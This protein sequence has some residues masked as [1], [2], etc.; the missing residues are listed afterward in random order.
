MLARMASDRPSR[1]VRLVREPLV[2]FALGGAL[3]FALYGLVGPR[4]PRG[5]IVVGAD[6]QTALARRFERDHGRA[7][8]AEELEGLVQSFVDEELLV[9]EALALGLD[10]GDPIVR[11]RL[12]Q[13]LR[14]LHEDLAVIEEPD[15]VA[16]QAHLEAHPERY[17]RGVRVDLEHVFVA[18]RG[19]VGRA[20]AEGL[21]E[22]LEGGAAPRGLGDPFAHGARILDADSDR[23]DRLFG[24][25][26]AADVLD[27]DL[28]EWTLHESR[29][30]WHVV[31]T[32]ARHPGELP[33]LSVVRNRVLAD[34]R[35]ERR[36]EHARS[37]LARLRAATPVQIQG[38]D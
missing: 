21:R 17:S 28:G 19:E 32:Q 35:S 26:F 3:I 2:Q 14:F 12:I 7:P 33:A 9:R 27:Q 30:G 25:G 11:R 16:L 15:E 23:L 18:K 20:R 13:K 38:A 31:R 22:R 24:P 6:T 5:P 1:W 36:A 29:L 34:L 37:E 10:R 4:Q 8:S